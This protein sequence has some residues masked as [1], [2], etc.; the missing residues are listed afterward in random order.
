[1]PIRTEVHRFPLALA[2]EA[3]EQ[4]RRGEFQGAAVLTMDEPDRH[5]P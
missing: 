1:V 2:N 5:D 3:L 4:L